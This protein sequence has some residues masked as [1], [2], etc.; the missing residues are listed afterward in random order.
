MDGNTAW[1]IASTVVEVMQKNKFI[2]NRNQQKIENFRVFFE[3]PLY[4]IRSFSNNVVLL[5]VFF[6]SS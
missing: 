3:C 6:G 4:D 2:V 5:Q 1:E